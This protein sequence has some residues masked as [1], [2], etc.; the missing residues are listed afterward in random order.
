ME[1]RPTAR[2]RTIRL[3][4][5]LLLFGVAL[6]CASPPSRIDRHRSPAPAF[7]RPDSWPVVVERDAPPSTEIDE[8]SSLADLLRH[9]ERVHPALEAARQ[10]WIAAE[11]GITLAGALPDPRLSSRVFVEPVETRVGPQRLGLSLSQRL[12]WPGERTLAAGVARHLAEAE[13][14]RYEETRAE[15]LAEVEE[16]WYELYFLERALESIRRHE[17]IVTSTEEVLRARYA[18][19]E[20]IHADLIRAQIELGRVDDRQRRHEAR[21]RPARTRLNVALHRPPGA[22]LPH[23]A[24]LGEIDA[25]PEERILRAWIEEASPAVARR[26]SEVEAARDAVARAR[27]VRRPELTLGVEYIVTDHARMSGVDDSGEDPIAALVSVGLP[28]HADRNAAVVRQARARERAAREELALVVD[29]L[30]LRLDEE[31]FAWHEAE[32]RAELQEQTL[33]PRAHRSLEV[34]KTAFRAGSADFLD[35]L[36]AERTLLE[37][38]L[39]RDRA[40]TDRARA[41]A[42]IEALVGRPLTPEVGS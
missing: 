19:G 11:E 25:L 32:R 15:L 16:A 23:P 38:E 42:R 2:S 34:V 33:L 22:P 3:A 39:E 8:H 4:P 24:E 5:L 30:R 6:S 29:R 7:E 41:H 27:Y 28:V 12:P 36:D 14:A 9:A 10:R 26:R 18:S 13:R 1:S 35:L 20:A 17:G 31:L 40:R 21:R 37:F